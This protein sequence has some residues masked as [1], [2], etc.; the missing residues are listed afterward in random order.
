MKLLRMQK[1][2][3][4]IPHR[5]VMALHEL[6]FPLEASLELGFLLVGSF[7]SSSFVKAEVGVVVVRVAGG[8]RDRSASRTPLFDAR[9]ER[10]RESTHTALGR[11]SVK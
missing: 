6:D 1:Y 10:E 7:V 9:V 2:S 4:A 8:G 5:S 3:L 11:G